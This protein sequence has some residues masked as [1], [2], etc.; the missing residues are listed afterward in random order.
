MDSFPGMLTAEGDVTVPARLRIGGGQI[1]VLVENQ[2]VGGWPVGSIRVR[3]DGERFRFETDT[4]TFE[5]TTVWD[6]ELDTALH[7]SSPFIAELIHRA[8]PGR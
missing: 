4:E 2:V 6:D 8:E 5:F 7:P 3:R 1:E